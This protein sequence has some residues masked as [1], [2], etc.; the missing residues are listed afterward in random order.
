MFIHSKWFWQYQTLP[1][2]CSLALQ[3]CWIQSGLFHWHLG[4]S[5]CSS[6][7]TKLFSP[8]KRCS[9]VDVLWFS[10]VTWALNI[11]SCQPAVLRKCQEAASS[12]G[13]SVMSWPLSWSVRIQFI[14][15]HCNCS[16]CCS[17][18]FSFFPYPLFY[19]LPFLYSFEC[20]L[21]LSHSVCLPAFALVGKWE[22][23]V[24]R[25]PL[26]VPHSV[27]HVETLPRPPYPPRVWGLRGHHPTL[28]RTS[29]A[30]L[31]HRYPNLKVLNIWE[32]FKNNLS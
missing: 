29:P 13:V 17:P 28:L 4:C 2:S 14:V 32:L 23:A 12:S 5:H 1:P 3:Q 16:L 24:P 21:F 6:Q 27:G 30:K 9:Y 8:W 10:Y 26:V 7:Q 15:S 11:T 19:H 31:H 22:W 18:S 25:P 20:Q